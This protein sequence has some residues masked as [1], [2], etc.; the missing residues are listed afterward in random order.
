MCEKSNRYKAAV[1]FDDGKWLGFN[2]PAADHG[3]KPFEHSRKVR[4][5]SSDEGL[6][7][8]QGRHAFW[9]I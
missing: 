9:L 1:C 5:F 8:F 2:W 6:L 3:R 4:V 7:A